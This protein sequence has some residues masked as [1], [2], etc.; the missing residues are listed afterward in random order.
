MISICISRSRARLT[1]RQA[2]Y[3][4][5]LDHVRHFAWAAGIRG[6]DGAVEG[7]GVARYVREPGDRAVADF[8]VVVADG[9]QGSGIGSV[10]I[11]SLAVVAAAQGIGSLTAL[12]LADNPRIRRILD[13][14]DA[15]YQPDSPGVMHARVSLP[16]PVCLTDE[17]VA[18]LVWASQVAAHPS[19]R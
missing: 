4:T 10:L 5:D 9:A 11:Q 3:L 2:A 17:T 1:D 8:A 6:P 14:L 18:A 19:G 12:L 15:R 7:V 16:A 13:R